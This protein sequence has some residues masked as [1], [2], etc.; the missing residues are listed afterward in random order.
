MLYTITFRSGAQ[1]EFDLDDQAYIQLVTGFQATH[2]RKKGG[3]LIFGAGGILLTEVV[4]FHRY[5]PKSTKDNATYVPPSTLVSS[6]R[7]TTP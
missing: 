2:E 6:S 3:L 5:V 4:G 7:K 1:Q